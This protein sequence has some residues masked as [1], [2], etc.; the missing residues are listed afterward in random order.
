MD[1][2]CPSCQKRL[3]IEDRFAGMV[4]KCPVC[5]AM[6]QAPVIPSRI[7][8]AA[9]AV[10]APATPEP[11]PTPPAAAAMPDMT[12]PL[13]AAPQLTALNPIL[14]AV[15]PIAISSIPP[16]PASTAGAAAPVR[17][18][19]YAH[20]FRRHLRPDVLV[21]FPPSCLAALFFLSFFNWHY[22]EM[23][24]GFNLWE[25]A[26]TSNGYAVYT[27]YTVVLVFFAIPLTGV[28]F[29]LEM[30]WIPLPDGL[31]PYWPWR[32]PVVGG[33]VGLPFLFLLGDYVSCHFQVFGNPAAIALKLAFRVHLLA[34]VC[35][36]LQIWLERRKVMNLPLPRIDVKW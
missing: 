31:R 33:A 20:R 10:S 7:S 11:I 23:I 19:E 36:A 6:L 5:S 30:A 16:P 15:P 28:V 26:F 1:L 21:W 35:C 18:G 8:V 29:A 3:T 4:V 34:V 13:P 2:V 22:R 9:P 17:P 12:L 24:F 14:D 25:L 32:F 27:L